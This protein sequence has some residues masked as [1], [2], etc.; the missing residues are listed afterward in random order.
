VLH[1]AHFGLFQMGLDRTSLPAALGLVALEPVSV[2]LMG[3][4]V[5]GVRPK[6]H[7]GFGTLVAAAGVGLLALG[8]GE[9]EHRVGG[10]LLVLGAVAVFGLYVLNG[11]HMKAEIPS[12]AYAGWV[13]GAAALA[14]FPVWRWMDPTV[15]APSIPWIPMAGLALI[16][17][18]LGHTLVQSAARRL[19]PAIVGLVCPAESLGGI[20]IGAVALAAMPTTREWIGILVVVLG[21]V[22]VL[23]PQR[24]VHGAVSESP[25][26]TG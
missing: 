4:F 1:A 23:R 16:P 2:I 25:S 7:E 24:G 9:G 18:V 21:I 3:W 15:A 6:R 10:D 5:H 13:Y 20:A 19:P 26:E 14:L 12:I 22:V 8:A 11:R 17:T